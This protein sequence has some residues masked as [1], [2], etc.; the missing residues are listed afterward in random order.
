MKAA[1]Q[2][3]LIAPDPVMRHNILT[4]RKRITI[5]EGHRDY[6]A[7]R[8]L[9]IACHVEPWAVQADIVSVEHCKVAGVTMEQWEADGFSCH[10][11]LLHGLRQ[12]YPDLQW[13][14]PVTVIRWDNVRGALVDGAA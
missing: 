13:D 10:A 2:A 6:E 7:G 8:Q 14:S 3:L 4:G 12:F 9:M 5:R 11:D 1:M